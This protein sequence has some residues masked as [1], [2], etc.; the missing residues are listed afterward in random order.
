MLSSKRSTG[1]G[2]IV[3]D[4]IGEPLISSRTS[5]SLRTENSVRDEVAWGSRKRVWLVVPLGW[6][7]RG[8]CIFSTL[9]L[10]MQQSH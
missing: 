5:F 7:G 9:S 10:K 3:L 1:M 2:S 6:E 8:S 4:L